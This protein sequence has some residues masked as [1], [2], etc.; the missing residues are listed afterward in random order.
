MALQT[1][2]HRMLNG[3]PSDGERMG[4]G[5]EEND[6]SFNLGQPQELLSY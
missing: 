5:F 6:D 2:G 3:C 1:D 4:I